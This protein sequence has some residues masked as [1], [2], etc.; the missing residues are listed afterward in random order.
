MATIRETK[1]LLPV[2][3]VRE[4]GGCEDPA[5]HPHAFDCAGEPT[6]VQCGGHDFDQTDI[7]VAD[8][9]CGACRPCDCCSDDNQCGEFPLHEFASFPRVECVR[10]GALGLQPTNYHWDNFSGEIPDDQLPY[11][12]ETARVISNRDGGIVAYV[13]TANADAFVTAL[14]RSYNA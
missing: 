2:D 11:G 9:L 7:E 10:C 8:G 1:T 14:N 13:H 3:Y 6:C 4:C 12:A 5:N